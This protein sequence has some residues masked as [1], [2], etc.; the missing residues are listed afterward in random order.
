M[1]EQGHVIHQYV[2]FSEGIARLVD[3]GGDRS[4]VGDIRHHAERASLLAGNFVNQRR[5]VQHVSDKHAGA[6][7]SH[8]ARIGHVN[9][10]GTA[11]YDGDG[12]LKPPRHDRVPLTPTVWLG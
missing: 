12:V 9:T 3:H 5:C 10:L 2:D 8:A 6:L 4:P 1:A 11:G 7:G